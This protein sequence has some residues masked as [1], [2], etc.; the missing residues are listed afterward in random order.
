MHGSLL[1]HMT[2]PAY[3]PSFLPSPPP[4]Y[5]PLYATAI[6][7]IPHA[8][9]FGPSATLSSAGAAAPPP[10]AVLPPPDPAMLTDEAPAGG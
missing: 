6:D 9:L 4:N 5:S 1:R 10:M 8:V 3:F 7:Q 2:L